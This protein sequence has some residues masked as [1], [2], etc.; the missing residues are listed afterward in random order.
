MID[1]VTGFVDRLRLLGVGVSTSETIDAVAA[2]KVV[3]WQRRED[4]RQAMASTLIKNS[5]HRPLFDSLFDIWFPSGPAGAWDDSSTDEAPIGKADFLEA[6]FRGDCDRLDVLAERVIRQFAGMERGRPV[7]GRYYMWKVEEALRLE[8]LQLALEGMLGQ[9]AGGAGGSGGET[10]SGLSARLASDE[11]K[12]R[13]AEVRRRIEEKIRLRL[14]ED[15]GPEAMA[16]ALLRPLPEEVDFLQA[17]SAELAEMKRTV[18]IFSRRLAARLS[19]RHHHTK[20][21]RPDFRRTIRRSLETGGVPIAPRFR[22]R[23]TRPEIVVICDVS[24]SVAAFSRFALMLLYALKEHFRKVRSFAFVDGVD[25]VT[26]F[27]ENAELEE[28]TRRIRTEAK[29]VWL[30]GHSDYGH[31]LKE[32]VLRY[33]DA[34]T[35]RATV[36]ILGDLRSNFRAPEA[37]AL[38]EIRERS[39]RLHILNPEPQRHWDTG[40][41][42]VRHYA[43][44]AD[45]VHECRNLRQLGQFIEAL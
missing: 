35:P 31:C 15:R 27:F 24:G 13:I 17:S 5:S 28:A 8:E 3:E 21:G 36:L 4:F 22:H 32:F 12:S 2:L 6:L 38:S 20:R 34:L 7:G 10:V 45:S 23:I 44:L 18:A 30:D 16:R 39:R 41:S 25:E 1:R 9:G 42:I 40:D 26:L 33:K 14:I 43:G 11:A 29:V 19:Y 37:W